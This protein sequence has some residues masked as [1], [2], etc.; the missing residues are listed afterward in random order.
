ML[1]VLF[2][3]FLVT[4]I[5][6]LVVIVRVAGSAGVLNTIGLLVLVSVVGAWLVRRQG[7]G[8][9]RRA[10]AEMA[11]GRMPGR[12]LVDGLLVLFAGA[13]MLTPG[14]VTDAI[15][16]LLLLS[17]SRMMIRRIATRRLGRS[18]RG[19][20][21]GWQFGGVASHEGWR[22]DGPAGGPFGG[23]ILDA[24]SWEEDSGDG[25]DRLGPG[26]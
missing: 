23:G 16:L 2:L 17:P 11:E 15:G 18:N 6:E 7:L 9:V 13:L 4:P 8:I 25:Q 22:Q 24:D 3:V 12:E 14:F 5:V 1:L 20:G 19:G 26:A 21:T 10:Q